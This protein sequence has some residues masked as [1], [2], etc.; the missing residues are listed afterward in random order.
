MP[1]PLS[2]CKKRFPGREKGRQ[3][4][5]FRLA[6]HR[7]KALAANDPQEVPHI[8]AEYGALK[9]RGGGRAPTRTSHQWR[10][11]PRR[12]NLTPSRW[13]HLRGKLVSPCDYDAPGGCPLGQIPAFRL[14][15]GNPTNLGQA[16]CQA[17]RDQAP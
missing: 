10:F 15:I 1:H 4:V 6:D 17:P 16:V 12:V 13:G 9:N 11:V 5:I 8:L 14:L 2:P 7:D 3:A